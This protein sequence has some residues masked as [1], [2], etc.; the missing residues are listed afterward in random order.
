MMK[1]VDIYLRPWLLLSQH[2]YHDA[3]LWLVSTT[4]SW[5]LEEQN[6]HDQQMQQFLAEAASPLMMINKN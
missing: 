5:L 3:T 1:Q 2:N 6:L 4:V